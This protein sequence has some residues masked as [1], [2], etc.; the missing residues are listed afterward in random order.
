MRL[1]L[2]E[3]GV[4]E[5]PARIYP[6]LRGTRTCDVAIVGGGFTGALI[7]TTFAAEDVHAIVLERDVVGS[8]STLVSSAL[9][10]QEP[11]QGLA[12]L[13]ARY[14]EKAARRIW[15]LSRDAVRDLIRTINHH[16]IACNL[17][18]RDTVHYATT[19]NAARRMRTEFRRRVA[20]GFECEWLTPPV[21]RG[22][23][24]IEAPGAILSR[25][26]AQF[27]PYTGC[28]GLMRAASAAGAEIYEHSAV[29]RIHRV[30]GGVRIHTQHGRIDA[31]RVVIA[32]GFATRHFRPLAGRFRM[33]RTYVSATR[34]L[35]AAE[36]GEIGL[37]D[38][39]IWD[40]ERPYHYARWTPAGRLLIGGA[41]RPLRPTRQRHAAAFRDAT[42]ELR[43]DFERVFP[44]LVDTGIEAA[45]EGLFAIT[46]DSLPYVGPHQRYPGH[47]F[48]LGYGGNGMTFG[49]LAARL[50][51]EYWRG[52]RSSDQCL[53]RFGRLR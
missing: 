52:E 14:G 51:L 27:N 30:R 12:D 44:A 16:R 23:T 28:L 22:V 45:W 49:S 48:A 2:S 42:R 53:F 35:T 32:T 34:P 7:A 50:L 20:A 40:T 8:G 33:Y 3:S 41:D 1:W 37:G 38:V 10:L 4:R 36:R 15:Q 39:M 17:E 13:T 43:T 29:T 5:R 47:L 46:P 26:G 9:L 21:L 6:R 11:D 25:G 24:S 31:A 18:E 19:A